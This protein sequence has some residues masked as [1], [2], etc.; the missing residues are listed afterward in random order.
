MLVNLIEC[1]IRYMIIYHRYILGLILFTMNIFFLN[2]KSEEL[3]FCLRN[4]SRISTDIKF[5]KRSNIFR[6]D[7]F[8]N[9]SK[10]MILWLFTTYIDFIIKISFL[11]FE[12]LHLINEKNIFW[13]PDSKD[14][15]IGSS[16]AQ[17]ICS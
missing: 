2:S 12:F 8:G 11:F 6:R 3:L 10:V 14:K 4:H 1:L 16:K 5:F 15:C 17:S 9:P 7:I 13:L